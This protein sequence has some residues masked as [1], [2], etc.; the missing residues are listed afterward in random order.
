MTTRNE[1][2]RETKGKGEHERVETLGV[3]VWMLR[4]VASKK[5]KGEIRAHARAAPNGSIVILLVSADRT[6]EWA[7]TAA[8]ALIQSEILESEQ[9]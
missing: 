6:R 2:E 4:P 3:V 5:R 9:C 7:R 1:A 8:G